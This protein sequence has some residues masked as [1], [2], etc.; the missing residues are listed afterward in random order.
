M[1][2]FSTQPLTS[3]I[4]PTETTKILSPEFTQLPSLKTLLRTNDPRAESLLQQTHTLY[5][6]AFDSAE[7]VPLETMRYNL[8]TNTDSRDVF[9]GLKGDQVV[10]AVHYSTDGYQEYRFA[11]GEYFYVAPECRSQGIGENLNLQFQAAMRSAGIDLILT[12]VCDPYIMSADE[13]SQD[14][15]VH[16]RLRFWCKLGYQTFDAPYMSPYILPQAEGYFDHGRLG[17]IA[18]NDITSGDLKGDEPSTISKGIYIGIVLSY[19][20][21]VIDLQRLNEDLRITLLLKQIHDIVP[22]DQVRIIPSDQERLFPQ[23]RKNLR[24]MLLCNDLI[25][26]NQAAI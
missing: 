2:H 18:L 15:R 6:G 14:Q 12:E 4:A 5:S 24:Q 20:A 1:V 25:P 10:G 3:H 7:V 9:L 22:G 8:A 17:F 16:D 26:P 19:L 23:D 11:V 21:S 13:I